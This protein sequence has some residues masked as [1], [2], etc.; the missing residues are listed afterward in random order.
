MEREGKSEDQAFAEAQEALFDYSLI[1]ANVRFLRNNPIGVPFLT[2]YYKAS[3]QLAK[4]AIQHPQRFL[5]YLA[6]PLIMRTIIEAMY[7]LSDDDYKTLQ[8]SLPK[9]LQERGGA[10]F[11]PVKDQWVISSHGRCTPNLSMK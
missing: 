3:A 10:Y 2:F 5:P 1:P 6:L 4:V 11:L 8:K 9:W 7:D